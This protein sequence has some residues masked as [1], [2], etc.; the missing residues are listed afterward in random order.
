MSTKNLKDLVVVNGE[1]YH[2][3]SGGVLSQAL[4]SIEVKTEL[5]QISDLS[6]GENDISFC[7]CRGNDFI[8]VKGAIQM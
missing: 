6:C 7:R 2:R 4:S 8:G 5:H 1:P 3:D